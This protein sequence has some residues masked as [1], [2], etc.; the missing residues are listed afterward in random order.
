MAKAKTKPKKTKAKKPVI[1]RPRATST[2]RHYVSN[3]NL[4]PEVIH[5]KK[6]GY[7]TDELIRMI[8]LIAER[9]STKGSFVGYTYREDMVAKAVANLSTNALKFNPEKSDNPFAFFTTAIRNSFLQVMGAEKYQRDVRDA[10]LIDGGANPSANYLDHHMDEDLENMVIGQD[11]SGT[12]DD[13]DVTDEAHN[14]D[15]RG[16]DTYYTYD[17]SAKYRITK[18][19]K[20]SY[21]MQA[22]AMMDPGRQTK[23][24]VSAYE[25]MNPGPVKVYSPDE[26]EYNTTTGEL[27]IKSKP[28]VQPEV[29]QTTVAAKEEPKVAA[30]KKKK[31]A[32]KD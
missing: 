32:K 17:E 4:L 5:S 21:A 13:L 22:R 1:K 15:H 2:D 10:V 23:R 20:L 14:E 24:F 6:L 18:K 26:Y 30:K 11:V 31:V 7:V 3:S 16:A 29:V 12:H 19:S 9:Y 25:D 28:D 8:W 27:T